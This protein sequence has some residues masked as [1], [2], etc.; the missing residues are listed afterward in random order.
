LSNAY[1]VPNTWFLI[2][3]Q[4]QISAGLTSMEVFPGFGA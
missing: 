4:F 3:L 1:R 2:I